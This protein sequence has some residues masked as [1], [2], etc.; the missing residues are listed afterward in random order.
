M[1]RDE[2][3]HVESSKLLSQSEL[4]LFFL[5]QDNLM[6]SRLQT[7]GVVQIGAISSAYALRSTRWLSLSILFLGTVLTLLIFFLMKRD[8]LMRMRIEEQLEAL[9]YR[10]YRKWYAPIKGR[11]AT[12]VFIIVLLSVDVILGI[13]VGFTIIP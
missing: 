3:K 9:D 11:E 5:H 13:L 7:M 12:W 2:S 4:L 1:D 8:E 6:W 10:V